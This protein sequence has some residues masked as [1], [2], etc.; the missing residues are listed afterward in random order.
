MN[1]N[2]PI[3]TYGILVELMASPVV[4]TDYSNTFSLQ[5]P[6]DQNQSQFCVAYAATNPSSVSYGFKTIVTKDSMTITVNSD[7]DSLK[8]WIPRY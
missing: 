6:S 4:P 1:A 7:E 5:L 3:F 8:Y 2:E